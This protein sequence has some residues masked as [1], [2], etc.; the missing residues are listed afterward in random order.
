MI[1]PILYVPREVL[2]KPTEFRLDGYW[3]IDQVANTVS[4]VE[5]AKPYKINP[6]FGL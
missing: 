3:Q 6:Y 1:C 2:M 4:N 5:L